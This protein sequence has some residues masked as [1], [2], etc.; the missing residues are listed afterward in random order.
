MELFYREYGT[1]HPL[2]V[3]HG[4]FGSLDNWHTL[5]RSFAQFFRVIAVD[6]RNHGRSPHSN[7]MTYDSLAGD[8]L[9]LLDRF[10]I[11]SAFVLGHSMGGKSAMWFALSTPSRVDKLVVVDIGPQ[12]YPPLHDEIFQAL[13]GVDLV[14]C[15]SRQ[16][17]DENLALSIGDAAVRQFLMKN[18]SRNSDG[19]LFWKANIEGLKKGYHEISRQID[20][21][22]P[23][24]KPALFVRSSRSGYISDSDTPG[25]LKLFPKAEIATIEAGHWIHADA[26]SQFFEIVSRFLAP[27]QTP[28]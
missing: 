22:R 20:S 14:S 5:S 8:L 1:G 28:H 16:Q 21:K 13:T 19:E 25:I 11:E 2:L 10:H 7:V 12:A 9:E 23:F 26:P 4:L 17:V 3:L 15:K 27:G 6:Q 24:A 18:L